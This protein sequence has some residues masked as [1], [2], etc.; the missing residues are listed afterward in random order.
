MGDLIE[1]ISNQREFKFIQITRVRYMIKY[2]NK[3]VD[4]VKSITDFLLK[5]GE[6]KPYVIADFFGRLFDENEVENILSFF[7]EDMESLMKLYLL[8]MENEHFDYNGE[9]VLRLILID[10]N[11]WKE[12]TKKIEINYKSTIDSEVF[13]KI[14]TMDNYTELIN[15][16]YENAK[17]SYFGKL[18]YEVIIHMFASSDKELDFIA[19]RKESWIK[20]RIIKYFNDEQE[21]INLFDVIS[22]SFSGKRI[23]FIKL[24]LEMNYDFEMFNKISFFPRTRSWSGSE[25]PI[26]EKDIS[27]L[28]KLLEEISGI[29]YLEHRVYLKKCIDAEKKHKQKVLRREYMENFK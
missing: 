23:K 10:I 28:E 3:G 26:I 18:S 8:G 14:W 6:N 24:F 15:M 11:F 4:I 21:M 12:I 13:D 2:K 7:D 19:K 16:A 27:F 17:S 1:F 22:T 29:E 5:I 9:L 25:V 20:D